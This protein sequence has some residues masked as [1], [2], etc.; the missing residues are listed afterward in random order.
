MVSSCKKC[1]KKGRLEKGRQGQW[2]GS[3]RGPATHHDGVDDVALV[4]PQGPHGPGP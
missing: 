3:G 4:V 1:G 2:Q